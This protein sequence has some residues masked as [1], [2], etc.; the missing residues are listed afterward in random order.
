MLELP[1][2]N[3]ELQLVDR[4]SPMVKKKKMGRP[5]YDI[6]TKDDDNRKSILNVAYMKKRYQTDEVYRQQCKERSRINYLKKKQKK[7]DL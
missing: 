4:I 2:E 7:I 6:V 5:R 3:I 1:E